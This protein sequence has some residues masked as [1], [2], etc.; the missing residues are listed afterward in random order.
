MLDQHRFELLVNAIS[1]YA[2]YML[3]AGGHVVSW[4]TGAQR[5][6]GYTADE[7]LGKHF[8]VFYT[9]E[10]RLV[11]QPDKA[12]SIARDTG[13]FEQEGWRL[14]KDGVRFW[15]AVVVNPIYDQATGNLIGYA[16]VTRDVTDR[17]QAQASLE[18][19]R[20]ALA[21]SQKMEAIGQLTGG[22][23]HDFNNFLTVI[24]NNL[25]MIEL[26]AR[27]PQILKLV[28][29]AL[30]AAERGA[31]LTQQLLAFA[32]RQPLRPT[33]QDLNALIREFE[34]LMRR[35]CG[36]AVGLKLDLTTSATMAEIDGSQ[37]EN[38]LL[39]LIVNAND[40]LPQGGTVTVRTSVT[41]VDAARAADGSLREGSYVVVTVDD[42]GVG[43]ALDVQQ[44]VFEPFFTT[45]EVG[46]GTGLGLSQV[47]GFV[48]QSGGFV[49]LQ[50]APGAG[51][52]VSI[53]LPSSAAPDEPADP[54]ASADNV[55]VVE[56]DPDIMEIAVEMFRGFG[57]HV[58]TAGN[59]TDALAI[60]RSDTPIQL[61][62]SDIVMPKGP[63]GVQLAQK[64]RQLRPDLGVIL[65]SGYPQRVLS[66]DMAGLSEFVFIAKPYRSSEVADKVRLA[67]GS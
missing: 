30:R 28:A 63:N 10:D 37:F 22:V 67:L 2:I 11:G 1:N 38:A 3:D 16:K 13:R 24:V 29:G 27:E 42:D 9:E 5:F 23:A 61:M 57:F 44:R 65:T 45:K 21:Q 60:L 12:L 47:E 40:A 43:M 50:S 39:N 17:L 26:Q 58:L 54:A 53:H 55:L 51:T 25:S 62:F 41:T 15:A 66:E 64:A 6:K 31:R 35:A 32:R 14:R 36:S 19:A 59:S 49:T 7:I 20:V 33:Q 34:S 52:S 48:S 46:K 8:S 56:D 18:Q 4:N